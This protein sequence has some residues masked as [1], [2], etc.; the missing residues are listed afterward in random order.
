MSFWIPLV[1][2][3][4]LGLGALY[5]AYA[6]AKRSRRNAIKRRKIEQEIELL[7]MK[8]KK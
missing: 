3:V 6:V 5:F 2:I 4:L 7:K 1:I 8:S